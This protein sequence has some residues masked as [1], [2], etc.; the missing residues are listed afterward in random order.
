MESAAYITPA[1]FSLLCAVYL[2]CLLLIAYYCFWLGCD[3][4]FLPAY[5]VIALSFVPVLSWREFERL[6]LSVPFPPESL[7]K[8]SFACLIIY[9]L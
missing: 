7:Q 5:C 6:S 2:L 4:T 3:L 1:Y 9:K 8:T